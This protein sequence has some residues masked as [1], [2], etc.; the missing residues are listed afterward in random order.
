MGDDTMFRFLIK[1]KKI[2]FTTILLGLT[3]LFSNTCQQRKHTNP[4]DPDYEGSGN[5]TM[6]KVTYSGLLKLI[7]GSTIPVAELEVVSFA[8]SEN[9][10]QNGNFSVQGNEA[11]KYQALFFNHIQSKNP[12]YLGLFDPVANKMMANDTSTALALTLF[13][14]YLIY[15]NQTQREQYIQAV[16]QLTKF[17]QLLELI[18]NAHQADAK[19]ALDYDTN[20]TIY[21]VA[22]Q[23]MKEAMES[24]EGF[25]GLQKAG[26]GI[27][28][29]PYAE[30]VAGDAINFV[31]SLS[32][33]YAA[34]IYPGGNQLKEVVTVQ[35]N[36]TVLS[37]NWGWP[38]VITTT[39][40]NTEY[41]L[42]NGSFK[43]YLTKGGDFTKLNQWNDPVGRA[44]TCNTAQSVVYLMD[45]IIGNNNFFSED[46]ILSFAQHFQLTP[47]RAFSL[48]E[49]IGSLDIEAFIINFAESMIDNFDGVSDWMWQE[50]A[51]VATQQYLEN[52]MKI[53]KNIALVFKLLGI[54]NEQAPFFGDLVFAPK[55]VTYSVTQTNG[56]ITSNLQNDPPIAEFS[57]NP[58][59]GIVGTLFTY[60]AASSTDDHDNVAN[61][62]FRWDW[63]T[64]GTWD[65][66]WL[67]AFSATHS[68]T[69]AGAHSITL[70]VKD[71]GGLIGAVTH[72]VNV[73]GGA[74]TAN[75]VKL[76]RDN[77]PWDS[78]SMVDMLQSLGFTEGTGP[79]TYEI[80]SSAQI[81]S[82]PLVPGEDLVIIS[83]D[84]N[85]NFYNNYAASQVRFTNFVYMGGS[86]FWEACDEGWANGSIAGAGIV[87]PGNLSTI[88]DYDYWNYVTDQ[89]LPLVAGLP[90]SMDHNYASH[91]SFS[92]LPDGTTVYCVDESNQPTLI[93]FN[94]GGGWIIVTGQPLEHQYENIYG[95][96]DMEKLLPS[97]VSYFTGKTL[98]KSLPKRN[99]PQSIRPSH[100]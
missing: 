40:E 23:I 59:A 66:G 99:L 57:V 77:L 22:C 51:S 86:L 95:A 43:L 3:V 92:N 85:Q 1:Y 31:N 80:I 19:T 24:L 39:P 2:F 11:N 29:P 90:S 60:D 69:E 55:D 70:E 25:R 82:V 38:P 81:A 71:S 12:V 17:S 52:S 4:L 49:A 30:D 33:W 28:D 26:V 98:P 94:L 89:N 6:N 46:L 45:L 83:N 37:Y 78:N 91:E 50:T 73:G 58:P 75:H 64:D 67:S 53:F 35:R 21:Q 8:K 93:E 62:T 79:N 88:F 9:V 56:S 47:D 34:G 68:Y 5:P 65:T 20:P 18:K 96:N 10:S 48:S 54:M 27:G 36:Q 41:K 76:F 44:T 63:D 100:Q 42:G 15:T 72:I 14:P 61:L 84:Q 87:L 74:G 32:I 16:K 7:P 13:N 97:I